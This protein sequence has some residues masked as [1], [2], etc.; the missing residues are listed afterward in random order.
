MKTITIKK[1]FQHL[2]QNWYFPISALAFF[3]LNIDVQFEYIVGILLSFLVLVF[4]S[5]RSQSLWSAAKENCLF[6]HLLSVFCASGICWY[7]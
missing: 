3:C 1:Y 4:V 7:S 5:F 6:V 2:K